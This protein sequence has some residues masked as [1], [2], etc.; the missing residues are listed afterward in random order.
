M[1]FSALLCC[2]CCLGYGNP[3][4]DDIVAHQHP[5]TD[6]CSTRRLLVIHEPLND[7]F[8]GTGSILKALAMGLGEA[9]HANR[10]LVWGK[11]IPAMFARAH[12][13]ACYNSRQGGLYDCFWQHI[14]S[15][16]LSDI[17][18]EEMRSLAV[19]GY[20]DSAR[21]SLQQ[22]RRGL[23]MYIPPP[24]YRGV[25][26]IRT[27]WPAVLTAYVF[28]LK[29]P[30][31]VTYQLPMYGVHIRHGDI[32]A[33]SHVYSNR[34]VFPVEEYIR[35]LKG[36]TEPPNTIYIA[37][38][39]IESNSFVNKSRS[40][41]GCRDVVSNIN[42]P[43]FIYPSRFR[44]EYGSHLVA[45]RGG[46]TVSACGLPAD[47]VIELLET[48]KHIKL[49]PGKQDR[50]TKFKVLSASESSDTYRVVSEA[51]QDIYFLSKCSVIVGTGVS[52]F[53]TISIL[54]S[55]YA[56]YYS[57]VVTNQSRKTPYPVCN[58]STRDFLNID[59]SKYLLLDA[60]EVASG[61]LESSFLLGTFLGQS[62]IPRSRG[63]ER[64]SSLEARFREDTLLNEDLTSK[65]ALFS[66]PSLCCL[67]TYPYALFDRTSSVWGDLTSRDLDP[68]CNNYQAVEYLINNGA[69]L[70]DHYPG[71][72]LLCWSLALARTSNPDYEDVLNENI[73]AVQ[74]KH[75]HVYRS[76]LSKSDT[77]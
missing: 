64:Y 70:S 17:T 48:D 61:E 28:R 63:H 10:T 46:C 7:Y 1:V 71:R 30:W 72:A 26:S 14:S 4:F 39:S 43:T 3:I 58:D 38:D 5:P 27:Q 53:T 74:N 57:N 35:K 36:V 22:A 77:N 29:Q 19:S 75:F 37:T 13:E 68:I 62:K 12:R 55:W 8:E 25:N 65:S 20:N 41:W 50:N 44:S 40:V 69:D 59:P 6:S 18:D 31:K 76:Q 9:V 33:L 23:A 15:C 54:L 60:V 47:I 49:Y 11:Y 52:H 32:K 45:A 66:D 51:I 67:P 21:V 24:K 56:H 42:C 73:L 34:I 2:L 16:S